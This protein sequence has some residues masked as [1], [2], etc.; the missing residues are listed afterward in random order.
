VREVLVGHLR[1]DFGRRQEHSCSDLV[2]R[3]GERELVEV[4]QGNDEADVVLGDECRELGD[5]TGVVDAQDELVSI[6]VVQRRSE[7]VDVGRDRRGAGSAERGDDVDPLAGA[8][9][10]DCG[11]GQ[12][13]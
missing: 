7:W 9:E 10:E 12:R 3:A 2:A 8:G 5:V 11:H 1:D 6:G 13:A 4:G